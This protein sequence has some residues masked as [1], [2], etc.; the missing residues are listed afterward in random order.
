MMK[1]SIIP[2]ISQLP[3][4]E[5]NEWVK[6][7]NIHIINADVVLAA[8]VSDND[9][10]DCK[11]A[12]VA[13]PDPET[14]LDY[15]ALVWIQSLWAGVERL[16]SEI[17]IP[18]FEIVRLIDPC[19]ADTMADAVVAWSYY[20]HRDM[21]IYAAQQQ[22]QIW[23]QHKVILTSECTIGILGLGELGQASAA[24]L[25]LNGFNII[26]WSRKQKSLTNIECFSGKEGFNRVLSQSDILIILLPL[27]NDTLY[28]F[29]KES[30]ERMKF[31]G[32]IIN[33]G[34]G[35]IIDDSALLNALDTG[36]ISH[37]V[38]D[39]FEQEPLNTESR[40][41]HD[42]KITILPHISALTNQDSACL[43]VNNNI[44]QYLIT[45]E[46]PPSINVKKGY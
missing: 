16:V 27:T 39:V 14:L 19:L 5:Q 35:K 23:Q 2:F 37:A 29:K 36:K 8:K 6:R 20:L 38:L 12:I 18:T 46:I 44:E 45:G 32:K 28:L 34:R 26:G 24:K 31:G 22:K 25:A 13:N 21:P 11:V 42:P 10:H 33:F 1:K 7:L 4:A 41:W 43:I 9:K 15:S 30:F 40:L 3:L 17:E